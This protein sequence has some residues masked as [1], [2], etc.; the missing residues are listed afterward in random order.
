MPRKAKTVVKRVKKVRTV[1]PVIAEVQ[2]RTRRVRMPSDTHMV[3]D[4]KQETRS[5][6]VGT[7]RVVVAPGKT[8]RRNTRR[9]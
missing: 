6:I 7:P 2:K 3:T 4:V 8:S 1:I 5:V 9:G